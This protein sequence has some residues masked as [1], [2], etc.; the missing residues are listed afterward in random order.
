[1][2]NIETPKCSAGT[3]FTPVL[4]A[5]TASSTCKACKGSLWFYWLH[6]RDSTYFHQPQQ[7]IYW[8]NGI[9]WSTRA[10]LPQSHSTPVPIPNFELSSRMSSFS[11]H[12]DFIL[13]MKYGGIM[14]NQ[15]RV[16]ESW[17]C[18]CVWWIY[19]A[20]RT[21]GTTHMC[22]KCD[23]EWQYLA[24]GSYR[25]PLLPTTP[26]PAHA[27]PRGR[28]HS[29]RPLS[30]L[31]CPQEP[32]HVR[33]LDTIHLSK[34]RLVWEYAITTAAQRFGLGVFSSHARQI[35]QLYTSK[36]SSWTFNIF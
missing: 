25:V 14:W 1:M 27:A 7:K 15:R 31:L 16:Y 28:M 29:H 21:N 33:S 17:C 12:M 8:W 11:W 18:T 36:I 13:R 35:K 5:H 9:H 20:C 6:H 30:Q 3:F 4:H 26:P 23:L 19:T 32:H 2:K 24:H 10:P 22:G 34:V